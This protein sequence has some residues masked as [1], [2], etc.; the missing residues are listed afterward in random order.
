M[1]PVRVLVPTCGGANTGLE[2]SVCAGTCPTQEIMGLSKGLDRGLTL[3]P[4]SQGCVGQS[5][6]DAATH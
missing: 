6:A 2:E 1:A 4:L 5:P 3:Q